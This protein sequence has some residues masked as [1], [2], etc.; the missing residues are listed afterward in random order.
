MLRHLWL[1]C[2]CVLHVACSGDEHREA[3]SEKSMPAEAP[4]A[5]APQQ[6]VHDAPGSETRS[7]AQASMDPYTERRRLMGTVF[8]IRAEADPKIARPAVAKAFAEMERIEF[9]LSEWRPGSEISRI[10][11]AAGLHPVHVSEETFTVVKS[12]VEMSALTDGAFDLSWAALH[13]LYDFRPG[14]E[15]VPSRDEIRRQLRFIDFRRIALDEKERTVYLKQRGMKLGT[16]AIGKGYALDR[17]GQIL[18]AA[19]IRSY[20]LFGGGQVQVYGMRGDRPYRV[21]I[22]HPRLPDK[23]IGYFESSGG[24]ISTSGDYERA[25]IGPDG[26]R[27]HHILDPRTGL[28]S[29]A[30]ISVTLHSSSGLYADA[31]STAAFVLGPER[32]LALLQS[33]DADVSAVIV[34][35]DCR[36][37]T[38]PGT[39]E[40]AHLEGSVDENGLLVGCKP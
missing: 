36:V 23:H 39:F 34:G 31:L 29:K 37:H 3:E 20:M 4:Q 24:S 33:L 2:L 38:T 14:L 6:G 21:G 30:S 9:L 22:Q 26:D 7:S 8:M 5:S 40:A 35:P 15:R 17:A 10:N 11:A 28:P 1:F 25:L 12:G 19:G 16:G 32:A 13:G 27:I 18:R